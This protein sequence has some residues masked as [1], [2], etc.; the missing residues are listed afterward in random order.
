MN[1]IRWIQEKGDRRIQAEIDRFKPILT[2]YNNW[3]NSLKGKNSQKETSGAMTGKRYDAEVRRNSMRKSNI[4]LKYSSQVNA[5]PNLSW[6][7]EEQRDKK[8]LEEKNRFKAVTKEYNNWLNSSD[9]MANWQR[10]NPG[11]I[12]LALVHESGSFRTPKLVPMRRMGTRIGAGYFRFR[13]LG[14]EVP[15]TGSNDTV[16][17]MLT[18]GEFV[19]TADSVRA[20]GQSALHALN[21]GLADIVPRGSFALPEMRIKS[22][23]A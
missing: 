3:N 17:A 5:D 10:D 14:G 13:V 1:E 15:G 8:L 19:L 18:P 11:R 20:Y 21:Q 6:L 9:P 12:R 22:P 23:S 7:Y 2:E 4:I 16:P